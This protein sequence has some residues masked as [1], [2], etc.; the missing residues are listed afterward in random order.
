MIRGIDVSEHNGVID[1]Q[2]VADAGIQFVMVRCSM[3]KSMQDSMFLQNVEGA[4][5]VGLQVGAYHY[6]YA[7]TVEDAIQEAVNCRDTI[8]RAGVFLELPVFFDM[9][10]A[11][12]YKARKGFAFDPATITAMC[13]AFID[14]V[15]LNCGVYASYSWLT[16]YIDWRSLG[17]AVWNAQ[18]G[19]NDDI[20][21]FMWQHTDSLIIAN[22]SFD[23]NIKY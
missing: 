7:L 23:G 20:K 22:K 14:N 15:G 11:D 21:G 3:G 12:Q 16:D 1:W 5:A 10:D 9:E 2:S 17:C 6:S 4:K 8:A 13:Q 18:W 19:N